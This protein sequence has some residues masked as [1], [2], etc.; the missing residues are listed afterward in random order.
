MKTKNDTGIIVMSI[1]TVLAL[2]LF[3]TG[4][5][6]AFLT[7]SATNNTAITGEAAKVGLTL[8]VTKVVDGGKLIPMDDTDL[9]TALSFATPCIDINGYGACHIY[10]VVVNNTGTDDI[11]VTSSLAFTLTNMANLKWQEI[12]SQTSIGTIT[13]ATNGVSATTAVASATTWRTND[14]IAGNNGTKTY[15]FAVWISNISNSQNTTD[16]GSYLGTLTFN[17]TNGAEIKANFN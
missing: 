2:A 8:D 6:Y 3:I 16:Y 13:G 7:A 5:T 11:N 4:G 12:A 1:V 9:A 15:Y 10:Q 17:S 14:V